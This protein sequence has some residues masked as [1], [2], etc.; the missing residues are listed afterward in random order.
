MELLYPLQLKQHPL[1]WKRLSL[2]F[3]KVLCGPV[4]FIH[5]SHTFIDLGRWCRLMLEQKEATSQWP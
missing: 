4:T 2:G 5:T 1:F 3:I